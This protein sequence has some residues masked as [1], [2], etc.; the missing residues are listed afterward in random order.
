MPSISKPELLSP[1]GD[2]PSLLSAIHNGADSVYFGVKGINM[3]HQATNFDILEIKKVMALLHEHHKKGYLALNTVLMNEDLPLAEKILKEAKKSQVDAVILWDFAALKL[4]QKY[5]LRIHLSTQANV[6]N[7]DALKAYVQLGVSRVVL[8]RECELKDIQKIIKAIR[9]EK[10][11]CEVETFIHGAMCV[12]ISGRC[13]MSLYSYGKSAN[14]GKCIQPCRREFSFQLHDRS[15]G[16][17]VRHGTGGV[18]LEGL[19]KNEAATD[20]SEELYDIQ[21][22][23]KETDFILGKD[24]VLSPKDLCT[25]DF[26]DELIKAGIHSFKI[27]GRMRSPEYIKVVTACYRQAIDAYLDGKLTNSLKTHL[28][29]ELES[30]YNRGFSS[31]FYFGQPKE[32]WSKGLENRYER[33]FVG[34]VTRFFKKISVA[35][36]RLLTGTIKIKDSILFVGKTTPSEITKVKDIRLNDASVTEAKKGDIVGIQLPFIV[37]PRDKVFIWKKKS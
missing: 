35:E 3:R 8:A 28:K 5:G 26:I 24:Y 31:G 6:S 29:E 10:I 22:T 2:W 21:D 11:N 23:D 37:K 36:V 9:K 25:I 17:R 19:Q 7:I 27:E 16:K 30:V 13:F 33:I 1:A 18:R 32:A 15:A 14:E 12:S 34:E 4:A 20:L